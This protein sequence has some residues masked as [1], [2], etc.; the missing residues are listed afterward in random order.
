MLGSGSRHSPTSGTWHK[1]IA[2]GSLIDAAQVQFRDSFVK[3]L[4]DGSITSL[5]LGFMEMVHGFGGIFKVK[6]LASMI[7]SKILTSNG[8]HQSTFRNNLVPK[9]IEI[10]VWRALKKGL[11]V[12][13]ELDKRGIDLHSVC[14]PLC[15]DDLESVDHTLIFCKY[16]LDVWDRIYK[17]W[18][19]GNF[20]SFSI[21][22]INGISNSNTMSPFGKKLW[23]AV[24]WVCPYLI[25]K[26]QNDKVFRGKL[27]TTLVALDEIQIKSFEWISSRA[28]VRK[29]EWLTWLSNP[30]IYLNMF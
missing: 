3:S 11:P 9:T 30:S 17:W 21:N 24:S 6:I 28:K 1:I 10:F 8:S 22:E 20:S 12:L 7:D 26:Q 25:W 15:D 18:N 13:L 19:L 5:E 14:C 23:Q 4:G 2:T 16:A 27:W 29:L